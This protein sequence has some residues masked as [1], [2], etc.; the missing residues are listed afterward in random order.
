MTTNVSIIIPC[1]N[2]QPYVAAAIQSALSQSFPCEVI[3]VDDGST[4]GSL[5]VIRQFDGQIR[6]VTGVNAGG[7]AARNAGLKMATG[8]FIQFL[9][10][11]DILPPNKVA[12]QLNELKDLPPGAI[13]FCPWSYFNDDNQ[14]AAPSTRR[15]WKTYS[16]GS[17]LLIDMWLN[18]GFFPP[19]AWLVSR[20]LIDKVG[21][22]DVSLTGDDDG[23]F[24]GRV[25]TA[26]AEVRF[27]EA[28]RVLYRNP[29]VG[30]VS[31]DKSLK[32]ARSFWRAFES[33]SS[34]LLAQRN[35]RLARRACLARVRK[36]AYAW[37]QEPEILALASAWEHQNY[38]FDF[39]PALP[40]KVR[41]LIGLFGVKWGLA[42]RRIFN[43]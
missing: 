1:Y 19:H 12:E 18:G 4:D 38:L 9:D 41:I 6:W 23:E 24:F 33:I 34:L 17:D 8:N 27:C 30:S 35:D 21:D 14:I 32:S 7:S 39:S 37:Q 42:F 11:D 3:V 22:W 40:V 10:A 28:T 31:R 2:K 13:A 26:A 15:Y 20:Q 43:R 36:T 25:L 5:D 29:P 16:C